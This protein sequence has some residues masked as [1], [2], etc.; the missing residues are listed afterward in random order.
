MMSFSSRGK[1]RF[2]PFP[3]NGLSSQ[4]SQSTQQPDADSELVCTW[5]AHVPQSG[6]S[7]SPFPRHSHTLTATATPAGELFL[8]GGYVRFRAN[9]DLYVFSTRDF[10]TSV[11]QTTGD[12]PTP[13]ATHGAGL[14]GDTLLVCGGKTSSG[15]QSV[16]NHDSIYLLNLGTSDL[17]MSSPTPAEHGF[18]APVSLEWTRVVINGPGPGCRYY[19][20]TIVVNSELFVFGGQVGGKTVNDMWTL[21]LN[22]RTFAYSRSELF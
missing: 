15:G 11:L 3:S 17:L 13:R 9:G 21:D 22:Y 16:S 5:S 2:N 1:L 8:F 4:S 7:P 20:T 6:S 18:C 12:V 19:Q 14:V 10:S